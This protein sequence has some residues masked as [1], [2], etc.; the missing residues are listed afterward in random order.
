MV[1]Q[2]KEYTAIHGFRQARLCPFSCRGTDLTYPYLIYPSIG[3]TKCIGCW[4]ICCICRSA[5]QT[6]I[7]L[8]CLIGVGWFS[9]RNTPVSKCY[10]IDLV[11]CRSPGLIAF[12]RP[13]GAQ[14]RLLYLSPAPPWRHYLMQEPDAVIQHVRIRGGGYGQT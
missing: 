6:D 1:I 3:N 13:I 8:D 9:L 10:R 5:L 12:G 7:R 4:R 2:E 14:K 11:R